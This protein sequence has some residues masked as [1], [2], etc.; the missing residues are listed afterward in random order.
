MAESGMGDV[1]R[2]TASGANIPK[3][4]SVGNTAPRLCSRCSR[5]EGTTIIDG[6]VY[7]E[8]CTQ[9]MRMAEYRKDPD[10]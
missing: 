3:D 8:A 6:S 10:E 7:C 2:L 1:D 4:Y 5:N 9:S